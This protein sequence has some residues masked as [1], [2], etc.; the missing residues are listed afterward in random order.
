M[1]AEQCLKPA[2]DSAWL[3][4]PRG[5]AVCLVSGGIDSPVAAWLVMRA[6]IAPIFAYFDQYPLG[7]EV[8]KPIALDAMR[9]LRGHYANMRMKVYVIPHAQ[10]LSEIQSKCPENLVCLLSRRM[11]LRVA[12]QIA[13]IEGADSIV[14]GDS[15]GQKA[16]QTLQNLGVLDDAVETILILRPLIGMNKTEVEQLARSIGTFEISTRPGVSSCAFAGRRPRTHAK[17]EEIRAAEA[18]LNIRGMVSR[19]LSSAEIIEF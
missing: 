18:N 14:T 6:G 12:E 9:R 11:M 3:L 7:D 1:I 5:K 8:G 4:P 13:R 2:S 17:L 15:I 16:S 10:D 19:A